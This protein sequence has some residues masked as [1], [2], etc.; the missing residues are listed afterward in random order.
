MERAITEL[1]KLADLFEEVAGGV[2]HVLEGVDELDAAARRLLQ[3]DNPH[4]P[5]MCGS[6]PAEVLG[7][8]PEE[9]AAKALILVDAV[10]CPRARQ[11]KMA[12]VHLIWA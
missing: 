4:R 5:S 11:Q 2:G 6:F 9:E 10:R 1:S 7:N 12:R 8:L 3:A